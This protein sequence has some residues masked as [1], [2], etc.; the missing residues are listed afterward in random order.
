[1]LLLPA[2]AAQSGPAAAWLRS[3]GWAA[4]CVCELAGSCAEYVLG[5][6]LG[7]GARLGSLLAVAAAAVDARLGASRRTTAGCRAAGAWSDRVVASPLG[8]AWRASRASVAVGEASSRV[9][10]VCT[11]LYLVHE[12]RQ[13]TR[14]RQQQQPHG[15]GAEPPET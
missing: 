15:L 7:A 8:A 5:A 4:T 11:Q 10:S 6:T 9:I 1:M 13:I 2:L 3:A 12:L 14:R